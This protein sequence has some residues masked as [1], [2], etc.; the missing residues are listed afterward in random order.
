MRWRCPPRR[1]VKTCPLPASPACFHVLSQTFILSCSVSG[2]IA[3]SNW[4]CSCQLVRL[5][6]W[7]LWH[8]IPRSRPYLHQPS[9]LSRPPENN[10]YLTLTSAICRRCHRCCHISIF[11]LAHHW[12]Q[13]LLCKEKSSLVT[14]QILFVDAI[15][16]QAG[17]CIWEGGNEIVRLL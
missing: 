1:R 15:E 11:H 7:C 2:V 16:A 13:F 3:I 6:I 10:E 8:L 14:F 4:I 5:E 12:V 9:T 17:W